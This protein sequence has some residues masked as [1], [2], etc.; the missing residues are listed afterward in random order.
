MATAAGNHQHQGIADDS[1]DGDGQTEFQPAPGSI[2][3]HFLGDEA[4]EGGRPA[5]E[6][7][8]RQ[9]AANVI[10]MAERKPPSFVMS[11]VPAS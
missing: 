7:A 5:M 9:A 8:A 4:D 10:G 3:E 2:V 6:S 11:R 1:S